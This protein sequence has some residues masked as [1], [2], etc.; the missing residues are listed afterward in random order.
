MIRPT[1][2]RTPAL[3]RS[4]LKKNHATATE[5]WIGYYKKAS[6]RGGM[7][8][9]EALDEALCFGWIDGVVKSIDADSYMQR[10]TPRRKG[11]HWSLVNVR[12]YHEL[13]EAGLIQSAGR[14]AYERRTPERTGRA[15]Y[16]SPLAELTPAQLKQ[17]K[18]NAAAW[19]YWSERPAGY[20]R[21]VKHWVTSAKQDATRE[22]R[23]KLLIE[24]CV[25]GRRLPHLDPKRWG[26]GMASEQ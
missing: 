9:K 18:A 20:H 22:R 12:R 19:E 7:I 16:E 26:G 6:G 13:E 5:L 1:F 2:F 25:A 14:A 8:Y 17:L 10:F 4:W 21:V 11:S 24:C 23:L 3:F 15:S